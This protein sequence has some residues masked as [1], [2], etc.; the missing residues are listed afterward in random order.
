MSPLHIGLHTFVM[1]SRLLRRREQIAKLPEECA[2]MHKKISATQKGR[3][4]PEG[5]SGLLYGESLIF[6]IKTNSP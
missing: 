4:F 6:G 5:T 3:S 1:P 2:S